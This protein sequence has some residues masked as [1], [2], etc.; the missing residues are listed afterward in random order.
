MIHP[1]RAQILDRAPKV[2][3]DHGFAGATTR[4]I[5]EA[6]EVNI[7]T[8]AYH[9]GNKQGVY[10]AVLDQIYGVILE[11]LAITPE[12]DSPAK[13]VRSL[14]G[15]LYRMGVAQRA[16]VRVLLRHVMTEGELPEHVQ[17]KWTP[18]IMVAA[19]RL[20]ETI[21]L[22]NDTDHRMALLS[23]NHL[24]ARYA[25]SEPDDIRAFTDSDPVEATADHIGEVAVKLLNLA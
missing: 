19:A 5:A 20:L 24:I 14:V 13:R 1:T 15:D 10:E 7:G 8:L 4:T 16:S 6:C 18:K 9:F 3:A 12:G 22:T 25:V 23:I 17:S 11:H 2:F 21:G